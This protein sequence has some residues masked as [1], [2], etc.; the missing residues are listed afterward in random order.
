VTA[1]ASPSVPRARRAAARTG[2]RALFAAEATGVRSLATETVPTLPASNPRAL[3]SSMIRGMIEADPV[4]GINC[5]VRTA[6]T[7]SAMA[8]ELEVAAD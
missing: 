6:L 4:E 7:G 1:E 2:S 3:G 5:L 8:K